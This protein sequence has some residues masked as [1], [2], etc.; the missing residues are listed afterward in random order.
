M[1]KEGSSTQ[2]CAVLSAQSSGNLYYMY[3][4]QI[5]NLNKYQRISSF[6][7]STQLCI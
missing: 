2:V 6:F 3:K 5:N 4:V 1:F 7:V